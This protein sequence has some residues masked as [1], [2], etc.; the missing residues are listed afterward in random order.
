MR[1]KLIF[2]IVLIALLA[3]GTYGTGGGSTADLL[4]AVNGEGSNEKPPNLRAE[5]FEG[6]H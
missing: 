6:L 2:S 4:S 3:I 5:R 1:G